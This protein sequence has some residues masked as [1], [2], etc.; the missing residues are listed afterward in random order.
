M[1][2]RRF[3]F[4]FAAV[5]NLLLVDQVVKTAAV[6]Y[7][8][9]SPPVTVL[10][11]LFRLAYVE[12]RGAAWGMFQGNVWPLALFSVVALGVLVWKR[13]EVF[14]PGRMGAV[15]ECLLYAGILGNMID[16]MSR[17]CVVDMFDFYWGSYHFPCFN[18]ADAYITVSVGLLFLSGLFKKDE[19]AA[20]GPA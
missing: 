11:N 13:R 16:R 8:K 14:P 17:G 2:F 10:A 7:L 20:R 3:I 15:A 18:V 1:K 4:S 5:M 6:Y 12:N 19:G 9:E